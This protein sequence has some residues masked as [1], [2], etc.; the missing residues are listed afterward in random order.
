[1][2]RKHQG[3]D[4]VDG[5]HLAE[6]EAHDSKIESSEGNKDN[7]ADK[8][9]GNEKESTDEI[10][11][12]KDKDHSTNVLEAESLEH[13]MSRKHQG[14]ELVDG[15]HLAEQEAIDSEKK[16]SNENKSNESNKKEVKDDENLKKMDR[17]TADKSEEM[18]SSIP[19]TDKE[20]EQ[21]SKE[22]VT[23]ESSVS[24][25]TEGSFDF[26]TVPEV[27]SQQSDESK[28]LMEEKDSA[29]EE[30][31]T[32]KKPTTKSHED[33][34]DLD[35][36]VSK[37]EEV[38]GEQ[39][40]KTE[41]ISFEDVLARSVLEESVTEAA[42]EM[43]KIKSK[44]KKFSKS[45]KRSDSVD[46]ETDKDVKSSV[47]KDSDE[48]SKETSGTSSD[49]KAAEEE[50]AK[51]ASVSN[52]ETS[53]STDIKSDSTDGSASKKAQKKASLKGVSDVIIEEVKTEEGHIVESAAAS[54]TST[55]VESMSSS[56]ADVQS[57]ISEKPLQRVQHQVSQEEFA[58]AVHDILDV[59]SIKLNETREAVIQQTTTCGKTQIL[60]VS[61]RRVSRQNSQPIGVAS[62]TDQHGPNHHEHHPPE[63]LLPPDTQYAYE[64]T[65][66]ELTNGMCGAKIPL[67][68]DLRGQG[69]PS[70][71]QTLEIDVCGSYN[72][73]GKWDCCVLRQPG[74]IHNCGGYYVY[75]LRAPDRCSVG[76]CILGKTK[77][78]LP[79]TGRLSYVS[80]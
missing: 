2:A 26:E 8:K 77:I 45:K 4:I 73:L 30:D 48:A 52:S 28:T 62:A 65:E 13:F 29:K 19:A 21:D 78:E 42:T 44:R 20:T 47:V 63:I 50:L 36:L 15:I 1:M 3:D 75:K 49:S 24:V 35:Q 56:S 43:D 40:K 54:K 71:G 59:K 53:P 37:A 23:K 31:K 38:L 5:I 72:I 79:K 34:I 67:R 7:E 60:E 14:D 10:S 46:S 41:D 25:Q 16:S 76:Y 22:C 69:L 39:S 32:D 51:A 64:H 80:P 27:S 12:R 61:A 66:I 17:D 55:A 74:Y 11:K 18:K 9:E 58:S 6:Q 70:E 68:V 33:E 57:K